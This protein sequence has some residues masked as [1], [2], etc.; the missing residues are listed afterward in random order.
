[1]TILEAVQ[2]ISYIFPILIAIWQAAR[3]KNYTKAVDIMVNA[4]E[5]APREISKAAKGA[6]ASAAELAGSS[7]LVD[8][9]VQNHVKIPG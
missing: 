7:T 5:S 9:I 3:A 4:I 2:L 6:V 8:T 1:M